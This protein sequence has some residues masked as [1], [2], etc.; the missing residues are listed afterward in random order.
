MTD[1]I[2]QWAA[3]N[4]PPTSKS[5]EEL[6]DAERMSLYVL[7]GGPTLV[8]DGKITTRQQSGIIKRD[9]KFHVMLDARQ[10]GHVVKF[11]RIENATKE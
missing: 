4:V 2:L 6:T 7:A 11:T 8:V 1:P 5:V 3:D 10:K 9:G